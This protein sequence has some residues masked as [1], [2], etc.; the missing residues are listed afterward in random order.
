M[1]QRDRRRAAVLLRTLAEAEVARLEGDGARVVSL[2][3][4]VDPVEVRRIADTLDFD[5]AVKVIARR[6][7]PRPWDSRKVW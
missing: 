3:D 4:A 5:A 2:L 1:T 6:I 7:A